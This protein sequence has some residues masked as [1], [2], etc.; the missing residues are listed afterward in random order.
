MFHPYLQ[1]AKV[2]DPNVLPDIIEYS[3]GIFL[4]E[5]LKSDTP[6]LR[7]T[8]ESSNSSSLYN[9]NMAPATP[10]KRVTNANVENF[11]S[12]HS[13]AEIESGFTGYITELIKNEQVVL[14]KTLGTEK[15]KENGY[16]K[17]KLWPR[18]AERHFSEQLDLNSYDDVNIQT[19]QTIMQTIATNCL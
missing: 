5:S 17:E 6:A 18:T 19:I 10:E 7:V 2:F 16:K 11:K 14:H 4:I 1:L 3:P 13:P 12:C 8:D 15:V 9:L